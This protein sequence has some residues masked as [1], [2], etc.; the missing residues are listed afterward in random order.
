M[1]IT[2]GRLYYPV[3][4]LG[5]GKRVGIWMCGCP[6]NCAGCL[7]D[8]LKNLSNGKD[9]SVDELVEFID[10]INGEIDG[11]TISGGEPFYQSESLLYLLK[12]IS[13]RFEDIILFT[14]YKYE[15]LQ[16]GKVHC[17]KEIIEN[18][19]LLID[20]KFDKDDI[21][22]NGLRG[23]NNQKI[24]TLKNIYGDIDFYNYPQRIQLVYSGKEI[25][26]IGIPGGS[27]I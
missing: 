26:E 10:S 21:C 20:G 23:S 27:L 1:N 18:I 2:I 9:I 5:P 7:S 8:E 25:V 15:E 17:A 3:T 19:S 14:G 22:V 24:I 4:T 13:N 11:I 6:F 12:V 16:S